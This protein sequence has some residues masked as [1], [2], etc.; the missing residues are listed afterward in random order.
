M[1]PSN[2]KYNFFDFIFKDKIIHFDYLPRW[3]VFL[4]DVAVVLF[5]NIIAYLIVSNLTYKYYDTVHVWYRIGIILFTQSLF[6]LVFKSYAGIIRHS[7]LVDAYNIVK[8]SVSAFSALLALNY[9]HFWVKGSKIFLF[10]SIFITFVLS[11]LFLIFYRIIVKITYQVFLNN[12]SVGNKENVIIYGTKSNSIAIGQAFLS[13]T[14]NKFQLVGFLDVNTTRT[15]KTLLNLPVINLS[16]DFKGVMANYGCNK[17]VLIKDYLD[18]EEELSIIDLCLENEITILTVPNITSLDNKGDFSKKVKSLNIND[19]LNRKPIEIS[20]LNLSNLISNKVVLVTGAAGSIGSEIS[21]QLLNYS[22]KKIVLLDQA[23]TP[24]HQ[25]SLELASINVSIEILY[26]IIDVRNKDNTEI[27]FKNHKPD[28]VFHAAAYKHVPLMEE[29][30]KQAFLTNILGTKNCADLAVKYHVDRFVM[31]STDKA[32]NPS[33]VMGASKRI[34]EKY[35]QSLDFYLRAMNEHKTK[36]I[37][38]RFGNVLGSNGSVVPLFTKQ[39]EEGGPVTITHPDI[40][41]YFMTI[42]EAC[43]LVLEAAR[44]GNGSEIYLFDMGKPV[45]IIELAKKMIQ[46][47]GFEPE[48]DIKIEVVGLRPGEKLF[49]ELLT[50]TSKSLPT[51]HE[52]IMIAQDRFDDYIELNKDLNSIN[53][54]LYQLSVEEFVFLIKKIVPEYKSLNS[55]FETLDN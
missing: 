42:P 43:Q 39:I 37:T 24:L 46:L 52:K 14:L 5:A 16:D 26:R 8:A 18:K 17:L 10:P 53:E 32:V 45:K 3:V 13:D 35:V 47:A 21:R 49:E 20:N 15:L 48:K 33:N 28:I 9:I 22:P 29:N 34:A 38:T 40:I 27:I 1:F 19:L 30:P 7:T 23:E 36:F 6:F 44:M 54:N 31:I 51:H 12:A 41:R 55:K 11:I 50:E 25:L 2:K 4:M